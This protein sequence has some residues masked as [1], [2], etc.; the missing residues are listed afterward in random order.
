M[1]NTHW[2]R[3]CRYTDMATCP[4]LLAEFKKGLA[5]TI[6]VTKNPNSPLIFKDVVC[7]D[8]RRHRQQETKQKRRLL[9][10]MAFVTANYSVGS[11]QQRLREWQDTPRPQLWFVPVAPSAEEEEE[12]AVDDGFS[13]MDIDEYDGYLQ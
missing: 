7:A 3:A 8:K 10:D 1:T 5:F 9:V 12:L 2:R 4:A 13:P 6:K 11:T